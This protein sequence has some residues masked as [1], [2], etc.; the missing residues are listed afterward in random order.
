MRPTTLMLVCEVLVKAVILGAHSCAFRFLL[1]VAAFA[2]VTTNT[3]ED[4]CE[5][6]QQP[7]LLRTL[8]TIMPAFLL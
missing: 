4:V 3:V 2:V 7:E 8:L 6:A 5:C 1:C